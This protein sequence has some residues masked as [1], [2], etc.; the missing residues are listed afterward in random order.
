MIG[1]VTEES[2]GT[3]HHP[4]VHLFGMYREMESPEGEMTSEDLLEMVVDRE[5]KTITLRYVGPFRKEI[6][7]FPYSGFM[8]F[9]A[10]ME[11]AME[12]LWQG[13]TEDEREKAR[14]EFN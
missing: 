3:Y 14:Y 13:M 12:D 7:T 2:Y 1:R 4:D 10:M 9:R 6:A 5:R 11:M 8:A